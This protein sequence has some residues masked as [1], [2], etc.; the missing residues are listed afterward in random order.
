MLD[1]K[2]KKCRQA[3]EKLFLR[4]DRCFGSKCAMVKRPNLPGIHGR[5]R[6]RRGGVSEYGKQ[7]SEK[8]RIKLI[9]GIR[10][11]QFKKYVKG[12]VG[13]KGDS[14]ENLMQ[15]LEMRLDN[16]VFRLGWMRSR[17]AARQLVNHGHVFVDGKRV[18]IPS[19]QTKKN[20]VI[21]LGQKIRKSDLLRDLDAI[22][23][24]YQPP[25]WLS[26]DKEILQG[27]ILN[28]PAG[29]ELGDLTPVGLVVEFYSR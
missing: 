7:L 27:K 18:T 9:Y 15:S 29:E 23:K 25:S 8:Q 2:C 21:S 10:E 1:P 5:R 11:R 17:A 19:Y 26:L 28:E 12:A 20:Q 6:Q 22:L 4:G 16:V 13:R 3:G 14:R 24:K